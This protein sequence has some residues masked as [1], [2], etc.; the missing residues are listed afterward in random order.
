MMDYVVVPR[1]VIGK[2][3]DMRVLR[4]EGA[5]MSDHFLVGRKLRVSMRCARARRAVGDREVF[6]L[7]ELGK[8]E[9]VRE[10]QE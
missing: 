3:F 6:K 10:Y 4:G 8:R 5:G 1:K 9:K 2:L 7:S